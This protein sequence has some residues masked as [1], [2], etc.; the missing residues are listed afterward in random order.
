MDDLILNVVSTPK[1]SNLKS[2]DKKNSGFSS[3]SSSKSSKK[4]G[5]NGFSFQFTK[6]DKVKAIVARK[7]PPKPLNSVKLNVINDIKNNNKKSDDLILNTTTSSEIREKREMKTTEF[8]GNEAKK[9]FNEKSGKLKGKEKKSG[10]KSK[11]GPNSNKRDNKKQVKSYLFDKVE[12]PQ[13]GKSQIDPVKETVFSGM[14]IEA[15]SIHPHAIKNLHDILQFK[16]LTKVQERT[17]PLAL[18]GKDIL[19]RSQTGSGKTLCYALPIVEMLSRIVPKLSRQDGVHALIV[20]PTRE[21]ALQSYELLVKLVKPFTWIVPGYFS[22]GEKRKSEKARLRN[23]INI[24]VGTPGRLCDHLLH[25]EALKLNKVQYLVLDEADRLFELGYE[26][27]VRNIVEVLRKHKNASDNEKVVQTILLSATLTSAVK[28]LAGLTLTDPIFADCRDSG[29]VN[30]NYDS[31]EDSNEIDAAII[32]ST[33]TQT[34]IIVPPKLR[35]VTLSGLIAHEI[36][37][38]NNKIFI[39]MA[40]QALVD[41]HYDI[42][43]AVLARQKSEHESDSEKELDEDEDMLPSDDEDVEDGLLPGLKFFKLHGSMTQV[44]R[45]SVFKEY[46]NAKAGVLLCTDVAARGLDVPKVD[47]IVQYDP[48][49]KI[50]DY[51]HRVGRTARAGKQGKAVI[52]IG[53]SETNFIEVLESKRVQIN[54]EDMEKYLRGLMTPQNTARNPHEAAI[55]LQREYEELVSKENEIKSGASKAFVSWVRFYSTFPRELR[56]IFNIKTAHMGHHA[57]CLGLREAPSA[58]AKEYNEP[59][60]ELPRNRLTIEERRQPRTPLKPNLKPK[61]LVMAMGRKGTKV[62]GGKRT[63][64]GRNERK[65]TEKYGYEFQRGLKTAKILTVSEF[66]NYFHKDKKKNTLTRDGFGTSSL[67]G[68]LFRCVPLLTQEKKKRNGSTRYREE[69]ENFIINH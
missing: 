16:E 21:L 19:I 43:V 30:A 14:K 41:Y 63:G 34:Y 5:S 69:K 42:M 58:F 66:D 9:T 7:R 35:L 8:N 2:N 24:L 48:P 11:S 17:I 26:K 64:S 25:T 44:E 20:V 6:Q 65:Y 68:P 55:E 18:E 53:P 28:E 50:H 40:T 51:V 47:V 56:P 60:P 22:G 12:L 59:K 1:P 29:V 61:S 36:D 23:G 67:F 39:F 3:S 27:D 54:Q 37:H 15:L 13:M 4:S 38:R 32:P 52:F 57:K 31:I 45:S 33:V 10:D 49:Q 46:R 62:V